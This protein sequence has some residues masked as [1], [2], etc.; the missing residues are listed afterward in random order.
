MLI[1]RRLLSL[2]VLAGLL[3]VLGC[4]KEGKTISPT[5]VPPQ[6]KDPPKG[7]TGPGGQPGS[8]APALTP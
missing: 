2:M 5:S 7:N 6:P 1:M 4:G 3:L 8:S